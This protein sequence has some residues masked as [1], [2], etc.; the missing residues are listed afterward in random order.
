MTIGL[1]SA[2]LGLASRKQRPYRFPKNIRRC[3]HFGTRTAK[4]LL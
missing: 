4:R 2:D 3:A 1:P